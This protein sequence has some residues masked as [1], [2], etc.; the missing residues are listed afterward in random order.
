[1]QFWQIRIENTNR[2]GYRCLM[3]PREKLTR[4]MGVMP[5][6]DF[7]FVLKKLDFPFEGYLHL[8]GYGEPLLDEFLLEKVKMS[9]KKWPTAKIL[10]Y[11]TLGVEVKEAL[12]SRLVKAGLSSI[13]ISCYGFDPKSYSVIH[14]VDRFA[15]FWKN[16]QTLS[17]VK[18][19]SSGFR[20]FMI[21]PGPEMTSTFGLEQKG[22]ADFLKKVE[23]LGVELIGVTALHNYGDGRSYNQESKKPC[24]RILPQTILQITWDLKVIPCCFDYNAQMVLGDLRTQSLKEIFESEPYEDLL[25]AHLFSDFSA[26]PVCQKCEGYPL[27]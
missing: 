3:C 13:Y 23:E 8:H 24:A 17:F 20:I 25:K 2:C 15:L 26:Y 19:A 16:L 14:G 10:F 1:M 22:K 11:T 27:G 12:F 21:L 4:P 7:S 5:F 18:K 9:R 6:S